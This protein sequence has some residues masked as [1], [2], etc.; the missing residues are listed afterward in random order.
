MTTRLAHTGTTDKSVD[1]FTKK[2]IEQKLIGYKKCNAK[3]LKILLPGDN[4]R[5]SV[6]HEFRGG[7]RVKIVKYP[8]YLVCMNVIK[9]VSWSVQLKDPT[10]IVWVRTKQMQ[11]EER[12]EKDKIYELYKQGQLVKDQTKNKSKK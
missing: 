1:A 8:E 5:Y 7:G 12:Q 10:L 3:D 9:N 2:K 6:N 4:I 11:E